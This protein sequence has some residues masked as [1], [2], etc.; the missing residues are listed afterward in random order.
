MNWA[1]AASL[2]QR[3][4]AQAA[5]LRQ[6]GELF[7]LNFYLTTENKKEYYICSKLKK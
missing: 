4:V 7:Y 6:R 2:R 1:Q 5:S 3:G